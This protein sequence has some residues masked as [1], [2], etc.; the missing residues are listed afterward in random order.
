[1]F[2]KFFDPKIPNGQY[3][4]ISRWGK[5]LPT[6]GRKIL[7]FEIKFFSE[8]NSLKSKN[9]KNGPVRSFPK[10]GS[11]KEKTDVGIGFNFD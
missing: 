3:Q 9:K 10:L 8:K 7:I 6:V 4:G 5:I 2:Y 1:L 11:K